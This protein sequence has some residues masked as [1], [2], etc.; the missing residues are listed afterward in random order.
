MRTLHIDTERVWRGGQQQVF[1]L[2]EGLARQGI[3]ATLAVPPDSPLYECAV[4]AGLSVEPLAARGDADFIA[5]FHLHRLIRRERFD[6]V[7]CHTAHAH[8]IALLARRFLAHKLRPKIV[9]A[10]RVAFSSPSPFA[11]QKYRHADCIVAVSLAVQQRLE[12][13]G[14]DPARIRVVRDGVRAVRPV[15]GPEERDR[16]RRLLGLEPNE[17]LVLHLGHLGAEKGQADLIAAASAIQAVV[18]EARIAIV[19]QGE[20]RDQL[21]QQAAASGDRV[22]FAGFWPP[23]QVPALLAAA[24][25]FVLPSRQEGLGSVLLEAMAAGLPIVGTRT[26]GIPEIICDG[27]TGLLVP[28]GD[29]PALA[30][31]VVRLL[32]DSSLAQRLGAAGRDF[33]RREGSA[34]RMI[35]ETVAIYRALFGGTKN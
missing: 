4:R 7:H 26:G 25:V 27:S 31:A 28:P 9:V 11:R 23:E 13:A 21:E 14:I 1:L 17:R 20:L 24:S 16:V 34:E 30:Q 33:V 12:A 8:G 6:I 2:V 3:G 32:T 22:L 15:V 5:S 19:G 35:E 18:P 10:R 29:S